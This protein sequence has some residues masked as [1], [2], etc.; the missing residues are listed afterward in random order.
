[1]NKENQ[2]LVAQA[3]GIGGDILQP[4]LPPSPRHPS[5][6]NAY[7]HIWLCIKNKFGAYRELPDESVSELIAYIEYLVT[8]P[9]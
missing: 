8:N 4:L 1:M 6:R 5:G 7:A 9:F 3:V 2:Q